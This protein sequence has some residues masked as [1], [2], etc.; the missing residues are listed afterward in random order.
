MLVSEQSEKARLRSRLRSAR[1]TRSEASWHAANQALC[2]HLLEW[3][4]LQQATNIALF[5]PLLARREPDLRPLDEVLR[6]QNK[7]LFYP[8]MHAGTGQQDWGFALTRS[9]DELQPARGLYEPSPT[10][11]RATPGQIELIVA[12]SLGVDDSGYRLGYGAGFYDRVLAVFAP[13]ALVAG[14]CFDAERVVQLPHEAHDRAVDF[15]V[16]ERAVLPVIPAR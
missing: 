12:P 13:P 16:T 6:L 15:I 2:A 8:C 5:W 14:V 7:S 11:P 3:Q 1:I 10:C 4:L 9:R